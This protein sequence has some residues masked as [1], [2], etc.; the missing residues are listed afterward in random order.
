[1]ADPAELLQQTTRLFAFLTRATREAGDELAMTATQRLALSAIADVGPVRLQEL[2]DQ[3]GTTPPTA[4]RAVEAL[5]AARLVRR[6]EDPR[7]RRAVQIDVTRRGRSH[8]DSKRAEVA[9]V[10]AP[11]FRRLTDADQDELVELLARLNEE[12]AGA[13]WKSAAR[14][15]SARGEASAPASHQTQ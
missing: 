3:I 13:D 4:S 14:S 6:V 8:V 7:D 1:M 12:L 11:A 9:R 15:L 2:A 5:V 10:L